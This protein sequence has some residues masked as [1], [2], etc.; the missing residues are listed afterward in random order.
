[1]LSDRYKKGLAGAVCDRSGLK[2]EWL[3]FVKVLAKATRLSEI[4]VALEKM[5][6]DNE[7]I[8]DAV[9]EAEELKTFYNDTPFNPDDP[10][11]EAEDETED[12]AEE[13]DVV[14]EAN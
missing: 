11:D 10:L 1:M 8:L 14:P 6:F 7:E 2:S 4:V 3:E 13:E 12:E 5:K 9:S